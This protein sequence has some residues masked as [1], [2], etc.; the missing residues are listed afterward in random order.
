MNYIA[1]NTSLQ[2]ATQVVTDEQRDFVTTAILLHTNVLRFFLIASILADSC[3]I[4]TVV[5]HV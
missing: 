3:I 2:S 4:R 5:R 1:K